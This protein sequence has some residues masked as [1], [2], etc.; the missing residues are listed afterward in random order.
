MAYNRDAAVEYA[1]AW[2]YKRNPRYMDFAKMGGDCTN[3]ISQ[4][5]VAGGMQMNYSNPMGWYYRSA[6]SRS[7]A[8]SGVE[9]LYNYLT[10][11]SGGRAPVAREIP[12]EQAEVGD[13]IQLSHDGVKF[14]HSLLVVSVDGGIR[15]AAHDNDTYGRAIETYTYARARCLHILGA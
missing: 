13:I 9:Y 7:A 4:C 5:L 2:A 10:G 14:A 12:I 8:F 6:N 15:V 1:R 3:F 11:K